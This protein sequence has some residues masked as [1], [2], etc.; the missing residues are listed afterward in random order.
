M[1]VLRKVSS[2]LGR[3]VMSPLSAK[4]V[5]GAR[6]VSDIAGMAGVPGASALAK[7][8]GVAEKVLKEVQAA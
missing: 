3:A 2:A 5:R 4:V 1:P 7:G 8:L 6:V